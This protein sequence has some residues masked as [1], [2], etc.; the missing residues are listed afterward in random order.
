MADK[1]ISQLASATL[2]LA[3]TELVPVVQSGTTVKVPVSGITTASAG[4]TPTGT[5]AVARSVASKLQES[6]SVKDFGAVGD[7]VADDTAAFTAAKVYLAGLGGGICDVPAG[8]YKLTNFVLD[9]PQILFEGRTSGQGYSQITSSVNLIPGSGATFVARLKGTNG[10]LTINAAQSSGF[11]NVVFN[12]PSVGSVDYGL[13]IDSGGTILEEV[14]IQG[15]NYGCVM[16]DQ[17]NSN[18]FKNCAFVL[19]TYVGI[20]ICEAAAN[21]YINPAVTSI[22]SVSNTAWSM[23]GCISRQNGFG[24]VIRSSVNCTFKDC[25]FES[26]NQAGIY[27]YRPDSS[28]VRQLNFINCWCENNYE[29]YT[30][31]STSF[32]VTGNRFFLITNSSTYIAWTSLYQAGYQMVIDSQTHYGGGADTF[33]F[34]ECAFNCNSVQQKSILILGG[35]KF[36]FVKPW[37]SGGDTANLVKVTTDAEAVHWY[38]PLAG[39]NPYGLVASITNSF[40]ANSGNR[41][42]YFKSGTSF[43]TAELGGL[44]PILGV[45]GGPLHFTAPVVGD[46][47]NSDARCLDDYFEGTFTIPW[48]VGAASPFT[49]N[50]QSATVTKIGRQVRVEMVATLTANATT[51]ATDKLYTGTNLPYAAAA[52]GNLVGRAWVQATGGGASVLNGGICDMWM[53]TTTSLYGVVDVFPILAIGHTYTIKVSATYTAAT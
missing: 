12:C 17:I 25:V 41:G 7:G 50:T 40:G 14:T 48:R 9:Q 37:F 31:G 52:L 27:I 34:T 36:N 42:A 30:S 33:Q 26:N 11:K 21:S 24:M 13:F 28:S 18:R 10:T 4:Y 6:V 20:G 15:F 5:G 43:G 32:S 1:K 47:R 38:D 23:E 46:P 51:A 35:F 49:V 44:Y 3:G 8:T 2:P 39:N 45:T 16:A 53:D 22:T 29:T 19:N